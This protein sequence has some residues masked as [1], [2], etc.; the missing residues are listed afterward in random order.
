MLLRFFP[1]QKFSGSVVRIL[2]IVS[3]TF[4]WAFCNLFSDVSSLDTQDGAPFPTFAGQGDR[5]P[6]L[7]LP[8]WLEKE[9]HTIVLIFIF[10]NQVTASLFVHS[11][12]Y[13]THK[14]MVVVMPVLKK[15]PHKP[16]ETEDIHRLTGARSSEQD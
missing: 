7:F 10:R 13:W 16:L 14:M 3:H 5:P 11:T 12:G 2:N 1:L 15:V 4:R 6:F 9:G 8:I